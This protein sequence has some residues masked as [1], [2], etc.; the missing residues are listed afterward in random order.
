MLEI[1]CGGG[2][3]SSQLIDATDLLIQADIGL[4]QILYAMTKEKFRTPDMDQITY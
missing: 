1:P 2:R 3:I 4:G